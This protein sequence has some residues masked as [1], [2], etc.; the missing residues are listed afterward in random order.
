ML[1]LNVTDGPAADTPSSVPN[2]P[3]AS[4]LEP[5]I[6]PPG[7]PA[8]CAAPTALA[9]AVGG[10]KNSPLVT[11]L[12]RACRVTVMIMFPVNFHCR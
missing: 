2:T 8:L 1:F 3:V 4:R 12:K 11:A 7:P 6:P 10:S 9:D 5:P